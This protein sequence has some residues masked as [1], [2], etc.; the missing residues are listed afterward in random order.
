MPLHLNQSHNADE[1]IVMIRNLK[2][3]IDSQQVASDDLLHNP[4]ALETV[5]IP[6]TTVSDMVRLGFY[7]TYA[8]KYG[9]HTGVIISY[10][11]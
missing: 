2:T 8:N 6:F 3:S 9:T 1:A 5:K 7:V 10:L 4:N 11:L